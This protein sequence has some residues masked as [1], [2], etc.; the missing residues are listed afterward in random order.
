MVRIHPQ[1][2]HPRFGW[3]GA[4][5]F[6]PTDTDPVYRPRRIPL[7][8]QVFP[9]MSPAHVSA[10]ATVGKPIVDVSR[11]SACRT[12]SVVAPA[13][14]ALRTWLWTDPS[15]R[16]AAMPCPAPSIS[17]TSSEA[18]SPYGFPP[19]SD[20]FLG[21]SLP[22]HGTFLRDVQCSRRKSPW[23]DGHAFRRQV[24]LA[25]KKRLI[26]SQRTSDLPIPRN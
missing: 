3:T 12:S 11:I 1:F 19:C 25:A 17:G 8:F 7:G 26:L 13:S 21:K 18:S 24:R 6:L 9:S 14:N 23:V 22:V 10:A 20:L 5:P 16:I 2:D 4:F 15:E